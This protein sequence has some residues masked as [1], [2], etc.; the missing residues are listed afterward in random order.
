[1]LS[2]RQK[3]RLRKLADY[4]WFDESESDDD[5]LRKLSDLMSEM[6]SEEE[7]LYAAIVKEWDTEDDSLYRVTK[8]PLCQYM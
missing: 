4:D 8:A 3:L 6:E 1:M 5:I 2:E 7:F